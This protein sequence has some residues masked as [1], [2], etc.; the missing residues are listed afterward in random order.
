[1]LYN[2]FVVDLQFLLNKFV[3]QNIQYYLLWQHIRQFL[4]IHECITLI[5]S[6]IASDFFHVKTQ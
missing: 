3:D 1:M 5:P 4:K 6:F 2:R